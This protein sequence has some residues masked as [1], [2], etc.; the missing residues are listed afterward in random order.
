MQNLPILGIGVFPAASKKHLPEAWQHLMV[1]LDS[2]II[3]FYPEN[4]K[5]DLNGKKYAWQ[6]RMVLFNLFESIL[7][8]T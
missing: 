6:V 4:F 2:T 7:Q 8:I 3:D 5:I 1:D